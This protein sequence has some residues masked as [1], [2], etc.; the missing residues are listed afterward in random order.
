MVMMGD[1]T[2]YGGR[3]VYTAEHDI[4]KEKRSETVVTETRKR[5]SR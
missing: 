3:E 1:D 2:V 4:S 5:R